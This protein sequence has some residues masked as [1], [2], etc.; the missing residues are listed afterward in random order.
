MTFEEYMRA[1]RKSGMKALHN[2]D[3]QVGRIYIDLAGEVKKELAR[4]GTPKGRLHLQSVLRSL[5]EAAKGATGDFK[6]LIDQALLEAADIQTSGWSKAMGD[7]WDVL[8]DAGLKVNSERLLRIIPQD[9]VKVIYRRAYED[10]LKLSQRVWNLNANTQRGISKVVTQGLARGL[11][12]DDPRIAQQLDRFL[13][14]SRLIKGR[15]KPVSKVITRQIKDPQT[16]KITEFS[17]RQRPVSY[18]AARLLR[19][20]WGNAYREADTIA[21]KKNPACLGEKWELSTE[22]PDIG[23]QCED[24]ATHDEGLGEGVFPVGEIPITPH[25][26]C[27]CV[28]FQVTIDIDEFMGWAEEYVRSGTGPIAEWWEEEGRKLAA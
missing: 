24:Y 11:H 5:T 16:G 3:K 28:T 8:D 12:Y 10:G 20:E 27:L 21:A 14:P 1:A 17:F 18:D 15:V 7:Y 9:A 4:A 19:T 13:Q 25:P 2:Y 26:Q 23:C 22:H 6:S